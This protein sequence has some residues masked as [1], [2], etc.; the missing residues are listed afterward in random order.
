MAHRARYELKYVVREPR[1]A[2]IADFVSSYLHPS[3]HNGSGPIRGHPVISLYFDSPD[4]FFYRQSATG[5]K[6]RMKL[7]IRFYDGEWDRPA[8]LEIKRRVSDVICKDRAMISREGVRQIL[9]QGWPNQPYIADIAHLKQGRRRQDVSDNFWG[10][11]N[12]S[13]A[14]GRIYVSYLREVYESGSDDEL[15]VTLDRQIRGSLYDGSGRLQV[16]ERGWPPYMP[17][18]L[19]PFPKDGVILE[20]KFDERPPRWMVE[21]VKTFN[22]QQISVCKYCACVYAQQL[23]CGASARPELEED[24]NL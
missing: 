24:L 13:N 2:A 7:R 12:T 1:A 4:F 17:P 16:P 8:F 22:L 23:H 10:F 20:L 6:N 14:R 21:L 15:R 3:E 9:S 18:Y 5:H 19:A 11:A